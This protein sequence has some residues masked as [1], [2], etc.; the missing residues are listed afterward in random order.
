MAEEPV[1]YVLELAT[2]QTLPIRALI[3]Q[4]ERMSSQSFCW[5]S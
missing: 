1:D 4:I 3:A 5:G 2:Q